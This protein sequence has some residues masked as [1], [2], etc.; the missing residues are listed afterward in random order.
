MGAREPSAAVVESPL[1]DV[2][3][4]PLIAGVVPSPTVAGAETGSA[5]ASVL[6]GFGVMGLT[7]KG[8]NF[9]RHPHLRVATEAAGTMELGAFF[10][11]IPGP[12]CFKLPPAARSICC[13]GATGRNLCPRHEYRSSTRGRARAPSAQTE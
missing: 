5:S 10:P 11:Q 1:E 7:S 6:G 3:V 12:E 13:K 4:A 9:V 8:T 2:P